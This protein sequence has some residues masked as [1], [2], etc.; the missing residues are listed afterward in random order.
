MEHLDACFCE[1]DISYSFER[2]KPIKNASLTLLEPIRLFNTLAL[3]KNILDH[4]LTDVSYGVL[5]AFNLKTII[6]FIHVID[7]DKGIDKVD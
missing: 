1:N 5:Q 3:S 6:Q 4:F 2:P 7:F